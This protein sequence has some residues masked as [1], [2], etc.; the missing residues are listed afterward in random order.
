MKKF[1]V[2]FLTAALVA[3]A[4]AQDQSKP[5]R[6]D[7]RVSVGTVEVLLDVVVKDKRGRPVTDL[8]SADFEVFEDGAKQPVESFRLIRRNSA[9]ES[10]KANSAVQGEA[11]AHAN[12]TPSPPAKPVSA[13]PA[14]APNPDVGVSVVALVFDRLSQD[15]RKRA[16]DAAMS[17]VGGDSNLSAFVGVFAVNLSVNTLQNYTT[18]VGLV[19][20]AIERAGAMA[21]SSF[22]SKT[23]DSE[24]ASAARQREATVQAAT[25]AAQSGGPGAAA[26]GAAAGAASVEQIFEAMRART[27]ETFETLQRDQQG[28]ATTNGLM[29][30]VNSMSRLPGR[31]GVLFFSEGISIPPNVQQHFRSVINAANRANVSVYAVDA[32]GLRAESVLQAA[33]EE[34][35]ARSRQRMDS[36]DRVMTSAGDPLTKGLERNEDLLTYNPE[37]GLSQ[38]AQQTGGAFIGGAN[39]IGSKLKEIDEDLG[40]YYLL[41][42]SPT[43]HNYDGKFRNI[44]VKVK[45]SG[46]AALARRG[47]YAVPPTGSSPMFYY[48]AP[49]L[50]LLSGS[51]RPKDFP[52]LVNSL[53]FPEAGRVGRIAVEVEVPTGVFTFTPDNEKKLYGSDF[54]FVVLIRDQSKQ[55]VEKLSHH[56]ALVGPLKSLDSEKKG[57]VLFYRETSLPPGKYEVDAVAYDALSSKASVNRCVLEIPAAGENDLRL[58]SVVIIQRAEQV[59]EKIDSPFLV[60]DQLLVYPNLGE[61]VRKSGKPMGFYF[62]VYTAKGASEAPNLTLEVLQNNK[63]VAKVPLKLGAPD[64]KGRIQ[65]ASALPLDSL[66]PGNYELKISVSDAKSAVSRSAAFTVEP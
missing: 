39:D 50:A 24:S 54:S 11:S 53:N 42:Y 9:G 15:G 19:K 44:S 52:L 38:L 36:L 31:K 26:A 28:Y 2:V 66:N 55:V 32:A 33:R 10:G 18:D 60:G 48:E 40:T 3:P 30:I 64:S 1:A 49:P 20:K 7:E 37:S 51:A 21:S 14:S 58:S 41:T 46:V 6:Q 16:N 27:D 63:S 12:A 29:A 57:K 56:Y 43:N 34:I 25:A 8:S 5:A 62:N 65:Y 17:Y 4:Q 13:S 45:R 61:P 47:Y 22:E 23:L 59:K 35:N